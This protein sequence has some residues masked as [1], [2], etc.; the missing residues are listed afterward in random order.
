MASLYN[1][2]IEE[3]KGI[4]KKRAEKFN[5][6]GLY[7]VGDLIRYYPKSYED[8]SN[9]TPIADAVESDFVCI[10]ASVS[11]PFSV[12]FARG[13]GKMICKT[14]AYDDSGA[15]TLL[16]FNNNILHYTIF[17]FFSITHTPPLP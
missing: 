7:S 8:W 12:S 10:K 2:K 14:I 3:L 9:V 11:S 16:Y 17:S 13:S 1:K 15:V 4:G 5:N 6:L